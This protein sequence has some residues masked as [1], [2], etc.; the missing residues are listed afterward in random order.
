MALRALTLPNPSVPAKDTPCPPPRRTLSSGS[1]SLAATALVPAALPAQPTQADAELT[2]LGAKFE[3]AL[4]VFEAAASPF[5]ACERRYL[6]EGPD[7]PPILSEE[8]P[9]AHLLRIRGSWWT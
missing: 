8:G 4:G 5:T 2:A 1:A 3:Q 9:L 7:P 6:R